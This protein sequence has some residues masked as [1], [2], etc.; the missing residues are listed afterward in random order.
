M[1]EAVKEQGLFDPILELYK[2]S[3]AEQDEKGYA[4][5]YKACAE[6]F[7]RVV[8]SMYAELHNKEIH[9]SDIEYLD[10]YYIFGHGTNTIVHFHVDEIP[11]WLFAIWWGE[12]KKG[13]SIYD[14]R[15]FVKGTFFTQY[16]ATLNKF[17]PSRSAIKVEIEQVIEGDQ[18]ELDDWFGGTCCGL[19]D[20]IKFM[21][22]EPY[23]AFCRDYYCYD[24]NI[25]AVSRREAKKMFNKWKK[26]QA[27]EDRWQEKYDAA[28]VKF[29]KEN[30]L[31]LF[32]G[33][34][35]VDHEDVIE[36][37]YDVRIPISQNEDLFQEIGFYEFDDLDM[38]DVTRQFNKMDSKF[39]KKAEKAGCYLS[40][41]FRPELMVF[42]DDCKPDEE[43]I[44]L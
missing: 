42:D 35:I 10:G 29:I 28:C 6:R 11:G 23:L 1:D 2:D 21:I 9:F 43:D 33:G 14:Q 34:V 41:S 7:F 17:K 26:H 19:C 4:E 38:E 16:E 5:T 40:W 37:R 3:V 15:K 30:V 31:P 18:E 24:Y 25:K 32:N 39:Q 27:L 22:D 12:P 13:D 44:I 20:T 8:A 36:P